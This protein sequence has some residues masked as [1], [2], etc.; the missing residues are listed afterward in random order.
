MRDEAHAMTQSLRRLLPMAMVVF[1]LPCSCQPTVA[2]APPSS[3]PAPVPAPAPAKPLDKEISNSIGMKFALIPAGKFL[4][5]SPKQEKDRSEHEGPQ[6]EV[7]ISRPFYLG[8]YPVTK[9]QFAAFVKDTGYQT[10][11]EKSKLG[12]P[13]GPWQ[14]PFAA[15]EPTDDDPVICVSWNEATRFS[16]WLSKKEKKTYQLPT[17]AQWEY[18]C[19]AGTTTAY[20]FGED[21]KAIGEYGWCFDNSAGHTHPVGGKKPN[22]WG[23]Y[24]MHGDIFQWCAD[25]YDKDHYGKSPA[26]DPEN[27]SKAD[28]RV[29][30]GG[31]WHAVPG[32]CRAA[33]R[34]P[35]KADLSTYDYGFRV[36]LAP[37]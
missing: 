11:N 10:Q 9:G 33:N 5:G 3:T 16:Q 2:P 18:A 27:T 26:K 20:S 13:F 28:K 4:M 35:E 34:L 14:H 23:L 29:A 22:P 17:E 15:Y 8:V 1:M 36:A 19:R 30:R 31:C 12:P 24:D 32:L 21:A 6:H 25:Y 37:D 7:E